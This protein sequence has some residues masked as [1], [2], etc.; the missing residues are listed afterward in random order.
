MGNI[1]IVFKKKRKDFPKHIAEVLH[2]DV[3]HHGVI[4][5]RPERVL[6]P[7][8]EHFMDDDDAEYYDEL[9]ENVLTERV[10]VSNTFFLVASPVSG[11]FY[12]IDEE[13]CVSFDSRKGR[14]LIKKH[15]L[16]TTKQQG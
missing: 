9:D 15:I 5:S 13:E 11:K 4:E 2:I 1:T 3:E 12:W 7:S 16:G 14:A 8:E 6:S 10:S